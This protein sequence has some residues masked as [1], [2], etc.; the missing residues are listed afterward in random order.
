L[1]DGDIF[2][3]GGRKFR[4]ES[5]YDDDCDP[6]WQR[7]DG[8]GPVTDWVRRE[9]RPN[10]R[11]LSEGRDGTYRYYDMQAAQQIALRDGWDAEPF[12]AGSRRQRAARAVEADFQRLYGWCNDRWGYIGIVITE[13]ET[14]DRESLWGIE[15]DCHDYH[16]TVADELADEINAR[17]NDAFAQDVET[18]RPDMMLPPAPSIYSDTFWPRGA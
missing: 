5:R 9:K 4:F 6:P 10:E 8:H 11:V 18:S 1:Y 15:S 2:E 14:G 12:H 16:I 3:R 17:L 13:A 7:E